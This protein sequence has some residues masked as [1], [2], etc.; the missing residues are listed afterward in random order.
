MARLFYHRP[1]FAILDECTSAVSMALEEVMYT[2]ASRLGITLLT[3]SHRA[4]LWR[5][6]N[7]ILQYDGHGGYAFGPLDPE[8]RL[9]LQNEKLDVERRLAEAERATARLRELEEVRRVL[10][11]K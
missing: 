2:W 10:Q 1:Q 7:T 8:A 5:Y 4:S 11:R 9:G 3:V 6:H